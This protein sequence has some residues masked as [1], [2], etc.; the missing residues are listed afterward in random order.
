MREGNKGNKV[1]GGGGNMQNTKFCQSHHPAVPGKLHLFGF[2][3]W[4]KTQLQ[5]TMTDL[6]KNDLILQN[7]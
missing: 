5:D 3:Q 4:L 1:R 2:S 7:S 6:R